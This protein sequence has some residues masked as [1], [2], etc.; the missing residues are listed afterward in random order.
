ME[1]QLQ[2]LGKRFN[3]HWI[4]RKINF[5]FRAG[6]AYA[7]TGP[8]GSGKS[9]LLQVIAGAMQHSEGTVSM[10]N[11]QPAIANRQFAT[12]TYYQNISIAAPYLEL[13][14]ELTLKEFLEFHFR[15]KPVLPGHSIAS[16]IDC[17]GLPGAAEKQLRYYSSGMKQRVK[18]AQA[19]FCNT[20]VV[21]LDEPTT[22]LDTEGIEMYSQLVFTYCKNRLLIVCSNDENEISFCKERLNVSDFKG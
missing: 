1:L 14:E 11:G 17:I 22:N 16:I 9:T 3:R 4:F 10:G 12:E 2:N 20:P 18:L 7:I 13:V 8:N 5:T 6:N 21:L 15:F 19:V